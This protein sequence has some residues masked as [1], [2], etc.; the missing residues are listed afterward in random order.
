MKKEKLTEVNNFA[1][2]FS[3]SVIAELGPEFIFPKY[4]QNWIVSKILTKSDRYKTNQI[5][6]LNRYTGVSQVD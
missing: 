2:S 3:E 5:L 4:V 6:Y 1:M